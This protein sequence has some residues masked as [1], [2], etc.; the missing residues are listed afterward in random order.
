LH[1][2]N[3]PMRQ[4]HPERSSILK[5]VF[6]LTAASMIAI[7][8]AAFL[9]A[10][11]THSHQNDGAHGFTDRLVV[12]AHLPIA[13]NDSPSDS[14]AWSGIPGFDHG[15][16]VDVL[17]CGACGSQ[18]VQVAIVAFSQIETIRSTAR[19]AVLSTTTRSHDPPFR[20]SLPVRAPP[21]LILA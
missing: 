9:S 8:A 7:V 5:S 1:G 12:H 10:P 19:I 21:A 14:S 3:T 11:L 20:I 13:R 16:S 6:R 2:H 15:K 18:N 17:M 4:V